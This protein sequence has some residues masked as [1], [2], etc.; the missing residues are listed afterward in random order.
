MAAVSLQSLK[1]PKNLPV[2][3]GKHTRKGSL[4][5]VLQP[6]QVVLESHHGF[7]FSGFG[8]GKLTEDVRPF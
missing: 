4:G 2:A 5:R 6:R 8:Y 1:S 3:C 7:L